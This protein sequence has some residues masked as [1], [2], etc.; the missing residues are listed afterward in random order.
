MFGIGTKGCRLHAESFVNM[1]GENEH[2]W[3][4]SH[5]GLLW[6]NGH[7][8]QY[9]KPF[10]EN[11]A[12]TVGLL[13]DAKNGTLT[14]YHDGRC[15]GVAFTGL[16]YV[17]QKLYPV[18]CSTA[19]KTEMTVANQR[20]DF[21][22]LQDRCREVI[23]RCIRYDTALSELHLPVML[24]KFILSDPSYDANYESDDSDQEM[25][26]SIDEHVPWS[27]LTDAMCGAFNRTRARMSEIPPFPQY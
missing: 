23:V 8:I 19:A 25:S 4:L 20:R 13:F 17:K 6:H 5:K 1:I 9:T 10:Q 24:Q 12:T 18:I 16:N 11:T 15:L 21:I 3:G 2:G 14:Y 7:W 22:S 27:S 26:S